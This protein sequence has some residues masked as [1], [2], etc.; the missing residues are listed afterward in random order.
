MLSTCPG[1]KLPTRK[2]LSNTLIPYYYTEVFQTALADIKEAS[3]ICLCTDAWTSSATQSYIAVTAH[4]KNTELQSILLGCINYD[5]RRTSENLM[6][7]LKQMMSD[8]QQKFTP[9]HRQL[10]K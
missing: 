9:F 10:P 6:A 2:T 3:A 4:F 1:Y 8:W 5:E 7:F